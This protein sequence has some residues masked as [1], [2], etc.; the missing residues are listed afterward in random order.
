VDLPGPDLVV[1]LQSAP[2][3]IMNRIRKRG[4]KF[5]RGL[6]P[7]YLRKIINAYDHFFFRYQQTPLLIVQADRL[8]FTDKPEDVDA[9]IQRIGTMR[10]GT[11]FWADLRQEMQA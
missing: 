11:E 9:L 2:D 4:R 6:S 10:S 7:D 1:Y 8:N 5:E 3:V